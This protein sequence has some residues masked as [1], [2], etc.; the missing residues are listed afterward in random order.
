[1]EQMNKT[2]YGASAGETAR[3]LEHVRQSLFE[4]Q[5]TAYADF[6]ARLI[7]T[8]ERGRII[9]VRTPALRK[10]A[11]RF[12]KS[13]DSAVFLRALPHRYYEEDNL[14][15]FLIERLGDFGE[16]VRELDR[17]L[18]YVDNWATC[19][20]MSPKILKSDR[21]ALRE[22]AFEWIA[23]EHVY[24]A[25]YAVKVMM[26]HFLDEDFD[27]AIPAALAAIRSEEYY[28]RMAIAWYFQ[29]ALVKRYDEVI[30]YIED[31]R[32][33]PWTHNKAIQ[34]SLESF[35]ITDGRK[36]YLLRLR[37]PSK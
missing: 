7:P 8:V 3:V 32:L 37:I 16:A 29:A 14:H 25:R 2:V 1:M 30:G 26:D 36:A 19:D 11:A 35:R 9:G 27:P 18:P 6:H 24:T 31:R 21:V 20:M 13:A 34:K 12:S 28:V 17:F 5:D 23:S 22:K 15:A 33:D 4:M 10:F